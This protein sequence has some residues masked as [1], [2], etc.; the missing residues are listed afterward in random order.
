MG[1]RIY[2]Q[3]NIQKIDIN[4]ES[5]T[6]L[7]SYKILKCITLISSQFHNPKNIIAILVPLHY[8]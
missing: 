4:T 5:N 1:Y 2:E 8:M 3:N 6:I 7:Y